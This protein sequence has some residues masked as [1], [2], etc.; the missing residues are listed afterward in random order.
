VCYRQVGGSSVGRIARVQNGVET[1]IKSVAMPNPTRN[2]LFT[3]SCQASGATLTL[4]VGSTRLS[5][6]DATFGSGAV[7]LL[8]GYTTSTGSTLSQRA[9]N[10]S[11]AMQ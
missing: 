11:A 2:V 4:Q 3:L 9:D 1:V 8:M 7:G 5:G 6:T 10:F